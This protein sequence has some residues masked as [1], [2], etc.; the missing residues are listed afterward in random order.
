MAEVDYG[1]GATDPDYG[2]GD[3]KPELDYGYG[4]AAPND[5]DYGYGDAKPDEADYGYGDAK[6]DEPDYGYGETDYGYDDPTQQK[7]EPTRKPKR[8]C[9]VT[10][11]GLEAGNAETPLTAADVINDFRKGIP[12]PQ[13]TKPTTLDDNKSTLTAETEYSDAPTA[14]PKKVA[15]KKKGVMGRIRKRLS[16]GMS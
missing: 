12:P 3:A 9:S 14:R 4:D 13:T 8:R 6:P 15:G 2:Y 5:A 11:Y 16:I 1:Y 10:K 7:E